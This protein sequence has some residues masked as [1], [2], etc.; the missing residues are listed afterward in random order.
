METSI[1]ETAFFVMA[2]TVYFMFLL[3]GFMAALFSRN[4]KSRLQ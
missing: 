3:F 2:T 4:N 1:M